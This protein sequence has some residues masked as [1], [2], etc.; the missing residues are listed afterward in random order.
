MLPG[1]IDLH[2]DALKK[3]IDG[4][5]ADLADVVLRKEMPDARHLRVKGTLV[6][7]R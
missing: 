1:M 3:E 7:T 6:L 2:C 5:Q 4:M